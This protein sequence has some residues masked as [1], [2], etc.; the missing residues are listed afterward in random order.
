M[1]NVEAYHK[2]VRKNRSE[3]DN[4]LRETSIKMK[5]RSLHDFLC[6]LAEYN[7]DSFTLKGNSK[8]IV[9]LIC[10]S[11]LSTRSCSHEYIS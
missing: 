2:A 4:S 1:F 5:I 10:M 11:S 6:L 9:V 7:S 3:N 8:Y